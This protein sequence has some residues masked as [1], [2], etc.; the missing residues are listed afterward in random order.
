MSK[1]RGRELP[2]QR[3]AHF[4]GRV[5]IGE[6][7]LSLEHLNEGNGTQL[8]LEPAHLFHCFQERVHGLEVM[9]TAVVEDPSSGAFQCM[10]EVVGEG[11]AGGTFRYDA[12]EGVVNG[13]GIGEVEYLAGDLLNED[14]LIEEE[15][16]EDD[17]G[18]YLHYYLAHGSDTTGE[19][20]EGLREVVTLLLLAQPCRDSVD[21]GF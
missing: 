18:V 1:G 16:I 19:F 20:R 6:I 12:N 9:E 11:D 21:D 4:V 8:S 14:D 10:D 2:R 17:G 13:I 5:S 7:P 3:I 15:M